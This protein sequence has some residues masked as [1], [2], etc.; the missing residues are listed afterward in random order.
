MVSIITVM[1]VDPHPHRPVRVEVSTKGADYSYWAFE[2][3]PAIPRER[4]FGPLPQPPEWG[5]LLAAGL[6]SLS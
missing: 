1:D 3:M 6:A 4:I 2:A 5:G